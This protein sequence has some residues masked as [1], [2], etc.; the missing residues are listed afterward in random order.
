MKYQFLILQSSSTHFSPQVLS[1]TMT[2]VV[3]GYHGKCPD[4]VTAAW[5]VLEKYPDAECIPLFHNKPAPLDKFKDAIVFIVDF[6]Y[7]RAIIEQIYKDAES[8]T[9]YDHH[10]T[11][12]D[13]LEGL[14]YCVFDPKRCGAQIVWDEIHSKP[15]PW[16]V[17]YVAERDL[18]SFK[19]PNSKLISKGMYVSGVF[20]DMDELSILYAQVTSDE[21]LD[22]Y[23]ISFKNLGEK[24][25]KE[26]A[27]LINAA[28]A[29][30]IPATYTNRNGAVYR[31]M[32]TTCDRYNLRSEI[33]SMLYKEPSC[34]ISVIYQK[35]PNSDNVWVSLRAGDPAMDVG[36]IAA[37]IPVP[38]GIKPG[39]GSKQAAGAIIYD[40]DIWS[41][42]TKTLAN[43]TKV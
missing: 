24:A 37:E 5:A 40:G 11:A 4:G 25:V 10:T 19:L 15:Y 17:D 8:L 34:D 36:A 41:Y 16:F 3:I 39:G 12:K 43:S 23:L 20:E 6:A 2:Q 31:A 9:V 22:E 26:E 30:A 35:D 27:V 28:V 18:W 13:D 14:S 42:F 33:G 21:E 7:P 1:N 29:N 38:E 32:V